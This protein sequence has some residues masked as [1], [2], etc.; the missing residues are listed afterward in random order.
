[1]KK[2]FIASI[3]LACSCSAF[4]ATGNTVLGPPN[5][6]V[7]VANCSTGTAMISQAVKVNVSASNIGNV[8]CNDTT[9][10]IGVAVANTAGKQNVYSMSSAGGS[11]TTTPTAPNAP[12]ASDAV[13]AANS[14]SASS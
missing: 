9:G 6:T 8:S 3:A 14:A 10:S 12:V 11:M 5:V 7:A 4:A 1:M 2:L 13:T